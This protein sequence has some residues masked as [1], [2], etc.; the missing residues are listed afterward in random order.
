MGYKIKYIWE[1]DW[2]KFKS[3]IDVTP[4]ISEF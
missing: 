2:K 1:L 4:K 3:G